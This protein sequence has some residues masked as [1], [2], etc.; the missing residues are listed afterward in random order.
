MIAKH[1]RPRTDA[2]AGYDLTFSPVKSVSALVGGRRPT[3]RRGHRT[4]PSGR[5][6]RR[7][8]VPRSSTRC[9]PGPA[10]TGSG[11]S[12]F[13][14]WWRRRSPI[15]TAGPATRIC[16]PMSRW[17]TRS[18][19][20]TDAG[21]PSTAGCCSK[22]PSPHRRPTTPPWKPTSATPSASG[23][24]NAPTP[25]R[26]SG[27]CGRSSASTPDSTS[28]GR[29]G[30]RTSRPGGAS[31]PPSSSAD[32]G[33]PPTPIEALQLA[34]QATLGDPRPETR[35]PQ[36]GRATRRL[37]RPSRRGSR[38]P[39]QVRDMVDRALRH[40]PISGP[41]VDQRWMAQAAERVLAAV[42][43]RRAT[44]QVWHIRAEAERQ[45]RAAEVDRR[46]GRTTGRPA[47][48]RGPPPPVGVPGPTVRR[49]HRTAAA[50]PGGWR[51][52]LHR[53]R[54]RPVHL[55]PDPGRRTTP[56]PGRRPT[57]RTTQSTRRRSMWRCWRW[58]PTAPR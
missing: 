47:R 44:W 20:S 35:T 57:R 41:Q 45:I 38:R 13:A 6:R 8:E 55:D 18:K 58:S 23:S 54:R 19:P 3:H 25:I 21:C 28:A 9:S 10:R 34:Q 37:A 27:R 32:H 48:R 2:V 49:R 51:Q 46:P 36:P 24:P 31:S 40:R 1:S 26:G 15:G 53:R 43:E 22:P 7:P 33:R 29:P 30:G 14:G 5:G 16:T 12:T 52:R 56:P 11:R 42:E 17:R 4:G 50:A 39:D